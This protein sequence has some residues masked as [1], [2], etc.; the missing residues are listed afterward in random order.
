MNTL[1]ALT[2]QREQKVKEAEGLQASLAAAVVP[3][4]PGPDA[5][6]VSA[7]GE[8][9]RF[10]WMLICGAAIVVGFSL[11]MWVS[12]HGAQA[13]AVPDRENPF[14]APVIG[15]GQPPSPQDPNHDDERPLAV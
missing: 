15:A 9:R 4:D 7:A 10:L 11:L 2:R 6:T 13:L 14:K 1:Q 8:D 5:V 12:S 3:I